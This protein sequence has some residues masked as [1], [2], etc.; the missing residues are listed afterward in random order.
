[1]RGCESQV[2]KLPIFNALEE[3]YI[4]LAGMVLR[5]SF[6]T[7]S[8]TRERSVESQSGNFNSVYTWPYV[9]FKRLTGKGTANFRSRTNW[10]QLRNFTLFFCVLLKWIY[11][12]KIFFL[13][14]SS[15]GHDKLLHVMLFPLDFSKTI[16]IY[17][18]WYW[19]MNTDNIFEVFNE[20][21]FCFS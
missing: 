20:M 14:I 11:I 3:V 21:Y 4:P 5:I 8:K 9:G 13:A 6:Q 10:K 2:Q 1:M 15:N 16:I 19:W 17:M 12:S 7:T 18:E